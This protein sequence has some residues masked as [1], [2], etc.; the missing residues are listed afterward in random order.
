MREGCVGL[1]LFWVERIL[2]LESCSDF[3]NTLG[4]VNEQMSKNQKVEDDDDNGV[5]W[6]VEFFSLVVASR[7]IRGKNWGHFKAYE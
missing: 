6:I 1:Q 5:V 2:Y 4:S 3:I 7:V